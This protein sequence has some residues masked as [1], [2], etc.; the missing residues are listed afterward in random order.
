MHELTEDY[1]VQV[2]FSRRAGS[3]S[4]SAK[5]HQQVAK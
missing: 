3:S 2:C 5:N 4:M 1:P